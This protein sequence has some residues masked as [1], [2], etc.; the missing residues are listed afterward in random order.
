MAEMYAVNEDSTIK[1]I[2]AVDDVEIVN[3]IGSDANPAVFRLTGGVIEY[4]LVDLDDATVVWKP[5]VGE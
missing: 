4:A 3:M 5:C 1:I 2:P